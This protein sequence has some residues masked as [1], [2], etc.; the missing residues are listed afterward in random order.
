MRRFLPNIIRTRI[1]SFSQKSKTSTGR[2][3]SFVR[4]PGRQ[5]FPNGYTTAWWFDC[6]DSML[7]WP[8]LSCFSGNNQKEGAWFGQETSCGL[9]RFMLCVSQ[10]AKARTVGCGGQDHRLCCGSGCRR[11]TKGCL[12]WGANRYVRFTAE[13]HSKVDRLSGRWPIGGQTPSGRCGKRGWKVP[14]LRCHAAEM[15]FWTLLEAGDAKFSKGY[16][17]D[18]RFAGDSSRSDSSRPDLAGSP[19]RKKKVITG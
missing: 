18:Y 5:Q 12:L 19:C 2:A 11:H 7:C 13:R 16:I 9:K 17:H 3:G 14:F 1:V 8:R 15:F 6:G 4:T 10:W